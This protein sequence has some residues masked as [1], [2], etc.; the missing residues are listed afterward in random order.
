VT[1]QDDALSSL[2]RS[3]LRPALEW[4]A[5]IAF[6]RTGNDYDEDAGHDQAIIGLHNF[7]YMRDLLDRSSGNGRYAVD[8][9]AN[10]KG[11]DFL[12]RGIPPEA[13][14]AMPAI[15]DG[16]I[17]RRDYQGS[18]GWAADG[19]RILLQSF[20]FGGIDKI[21]WGQRSEAKRTVASQLY[22]G[23]TPLFEDEDFGL[24]SLP[25][26]PDDQDYD[27]LTLVAAHGY[28]PTTSQF[29]LYVGQS[30]NPEFR[31]DGCWHWRTLL[32]SGGADVVAPILD[33]NGPLPGAPAGASVDDVEIRP[34][35]RPD[36]KS[37]TDPA[38]RNG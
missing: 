8:P 19:H 16:T 33:V 23:G 37:G 29:E 38:P 20:K 15:A 31:G 13:L 7:V 21:K 18:A 22:V 30:K 3:G 28:D 26:V 27:G 24:E 14:V 25:G 2:T 5:P 11:R 34:K 35:Q 36:D 9:A 6:A 1:A 17:M 4:A 10:G 12:G 32:L